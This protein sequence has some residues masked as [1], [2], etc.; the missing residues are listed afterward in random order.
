MKTKRGVQMPVRA[1]KDSAGYDFFAPKDIVIKAGEWTEFGTG[2]FLDGTERPVM[3]L[4]RHD[5]YTGFDASVEFQPDDWVLMLHPR[6]GLGFK[7]RVRIANTTGIIDQ[8]YKEEIRCKLSADV[9]VTI[10]KGTAYMQGVFL[11]YLTL[12]GEEEPTETR[13]GGFGSTDK[14][15]E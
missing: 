1:T 12:M 13:K 2:V 7:H 8:D 15:K 11:P 5:P 4:T 9:D 10:P 3:T 14:R 6:S